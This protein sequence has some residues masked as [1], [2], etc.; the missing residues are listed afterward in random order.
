MC[1]GLCF[2]IF[3]FGLLLVISTSIFTLI[4]VGEAGS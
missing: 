3:C 4:L 1:F 2:Q